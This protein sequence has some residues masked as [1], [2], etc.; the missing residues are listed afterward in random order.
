[1]GETHIPIKALVNCTS[2]WKSYYK[3]SK[4]GQNVQNSCA[5]KNVMCHKIERIGKIL[6]GQLQ[7]IAHEY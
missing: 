7:Y 3:L 6:K 1:M 5:L 4:V 2:L